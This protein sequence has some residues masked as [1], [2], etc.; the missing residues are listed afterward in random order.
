MI[1]CSPGCINGGVFRVVLHLS[2]FC[3][4]SVSRDVFGQP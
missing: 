2:V 3:A 4:C 1:V